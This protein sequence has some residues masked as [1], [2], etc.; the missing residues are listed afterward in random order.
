MQ[1]TKRQILKSERIEARVTAEQKAIIQRA[2][3]LQGRTI[4]DFIVSVLHDTAER[5]IREY[6][7]INLTNRERELFVDAMLN[8]PKANEKF[9]AHAKFY[10]QTLKGG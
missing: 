10:K 8:S 3:E 9:L 5:T 6:E 1:P 2:A 7:I 4:T